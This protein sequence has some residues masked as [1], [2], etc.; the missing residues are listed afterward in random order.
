MEG[1]AST[2]L[3]LPS[4][5]PPLLTGAIGHVCGNRPVPKAVDSQTRANNED[6]FM[7]DDF[8][9]TI[10][11][12]PLEGHLSTDNK[13]VPY[14]YMQFP[15]T[16]EDSRETTVC[17]DTGCSSVMVCENWLA[18]YAPNAQITTVPPIFS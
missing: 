18:T 5:S 3:S 15:V 6:A 1:F 12:E 8:L 17:A 13:L 7:S 11:A 14:T 16:L 4:Y 2:L 9:D 10:I